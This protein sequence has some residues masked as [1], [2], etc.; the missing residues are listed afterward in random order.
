MFES[1]FQKSVWER[2]TRDVTMTI[3]DLDGQNFDMA[4]VLGT[5]ILSVYSVYVYFTTS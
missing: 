1:L 4:F 5:K 3:G 2:H